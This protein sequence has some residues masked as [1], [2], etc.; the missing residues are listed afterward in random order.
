MIFSVIVFACSISDYEAGTCKFTDT[1]P[2]EVGRVMFDER[3]CAKYG[4]ESI[5]NSSLKPKEDEVLTSVCI[6]M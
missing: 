6:K 3:D 1:K 2:F 4:Q 5:S